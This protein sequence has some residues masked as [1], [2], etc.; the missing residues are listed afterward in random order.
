MRPV[1][2]PLETPRL[3]A[4]LFCALLLAACQ[5][6]PGPASLAEDACAGAASRLAVIQGE[7]FRSPLLGRQVTAGGVVTLVLPGS[8]VFV[9]EPG[10]DAQ[11]ATSDALFLQDS[12][13]AEQARAGDRLV[14]TG[15]VT[16]LGEGRDSIT[17]LSEILGFRTCESG[18]PLPETATA[19]PLDEREREAL[20]GMRVRFAQQLYVADPW[21]AG[22]GELTL[23]GERVLPAPTEVA[24]PGKDARERAA[25]N[26]DNTLN[27]R[28][29]DG[30]GQLPPAG[31]G[32]LSLTGVMAHGGGGQRLIADGPLHTVP[33]R[34]SRVPPPGEAD[35]RVVALNLH[36][37]FNG[38]GRGGGF[39]T[40]RGAKTPAEF[41]AQRARLAAQI[42]HLQPHVVAVMELENDGFGLHSAALD[43]IV[44]L[45][46]GTGHAWHAV[47]PEF[48]YIGRD[49]IRVGIFIR[50][51]RVQASGFPEF[52]DGPDFEGLSR[53]P[54]AQV[55]VDRA[56]GEPFLLVVNHLK[57]KGSCPDGGPNANKG[58][59]QGCWN[60]ARTAAANSMARW[61]RLLAD[62]HAGGRALVVGDMNA[63][64]MEDPVTAILDAGFLDLNP[65]E[66]L[67][68]EFSTIFYGLA[69][70]L[71]YAFATPELRRFVQASM[72]PNLNS[73]YARDLELPQPWLGASDHDPVVV[74]LRLRQ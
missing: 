17:S 60:P 53:V 32:V 61:S 56:R 44:D 58:D 64:H 49:V 34:L 42:E 66:P 57:S 63:Y 16:E 7:G 55:L 18:L 72:V 47:R 36:N 14:A 15:T 25:E 21:A 74:D 13:L 4:F 23:A 50:E 43:F 30:D 31:A 51:D 26:R 52:L 73:I 9:E 40:E 11:A 35:L 28:L 19:M 65:P 37:Y 41:A 2:P 10:S 45:E 39:P 46:D 69:G 5:R 20:E 71:D 59:G 33:P 67:E 38:D 27:I 1:T 6:G 24:R 48:D 62:R 22:R 54:M 12:A 3:A 8:G 68:P 70:T 29:A